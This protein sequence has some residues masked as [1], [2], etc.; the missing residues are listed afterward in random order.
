VEPSFIAYNDCA[1]D[2]DS[3]YGTGGNVANLGAEDS[4]GNLVPAGQ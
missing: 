3:Q 4:A 1:D 2:Q